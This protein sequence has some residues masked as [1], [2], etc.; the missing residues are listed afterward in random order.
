MQIKIIKES[1]ENMDLGIMLVIV[2]SLWSITKTL[3]KLAIKVMEKQ[4]KQNE[5]LEKII[6]TLE[7]KR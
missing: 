7:E 2:L 3:E 4:D 6:S 1:G 5:L